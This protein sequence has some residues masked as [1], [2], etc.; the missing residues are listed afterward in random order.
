MDCGLP[1]SSVHGDSPSKNTGV[2]YHA[3]LQGIFPT[4]GSNPGLPQYRR[5]L[6]HLSHQGSPLHLILN[7]PKYT[8]VL[9]PNAVLLCH[10]TTTRGQN[11]T[12]NGSNTEEPDCPFSRLKS[13]G[14]PIADNKIPEVR[15]IEVVRITLLNSV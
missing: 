11:L 4:Q 5:I 2:S 1:G 14:N 3:L 10:S 9:Q 12:A 8:G 7:L 15:S 13:Y 6:Y